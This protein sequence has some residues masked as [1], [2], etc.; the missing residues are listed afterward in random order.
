MHRLYIL[1]L[2]FLLSLLATAK[3]FT[4][5]IDAGHGGKDPGAVGAKLKE[6]DINLRVALAL[7]KLLE[8]E[9]DVNV[10]YTRKTDVFVELSERAHIANK[11]KADLFLSIHTNASAGN[12]SVNGTETYTL[13][14]HRA[15]SNLEVAKRENSAIMLEKDYE[16]RYEGFDPKSAES[17]IIFELMQDQ[18]MKQSV[19]LAQR[20]QTQFATTAK[21]NNRGVHQAGFLVLHATSMPS[22]LVE[23]GYITTPSEEQYLATQTATDNLSRSLFNAIKQY[24]NNQ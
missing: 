24:R 9:Q 21:R 5:V 14:M 3:P 13:G 8:G 2:S 22:V 12:K 23:V 20:I 16:Q 18:H 1:T 10:V 15:A 4:I 7:G 6:K 11:N 19:S 17:Y